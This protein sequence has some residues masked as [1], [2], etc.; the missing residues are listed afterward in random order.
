MGLF[1][2]Y[3]HYIPLCRIETATPTN[4][5]ANS[6]HHIYFIQIQ[7]WRWCRHRPRPRWWWRHVPMLFLYDSL[8][9]SS[10]SSFSLLNI[11]I[12]SSF[13]RYSILNGNA[14]NGG[15][16]SSDS[17][18]GGGSVD[19]LRPYIYLFIRAGA[20][21]P[22]IRRVRVYCLLFWAQ[23]IRSVKCHHHRVHRNWL[24]ALRVLLSPTKSIVR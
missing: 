19:K 3:I 22:F 24:N 15:G 23:S 2:N 16:I 14:G 1:A 20:R 4:S 5:I 12:K 6:A 18:R 8:F 13:Y 9:P 7:K 21:T 10:S 11:I 17:R